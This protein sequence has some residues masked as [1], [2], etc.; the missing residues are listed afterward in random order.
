MIES[1]HPWAQ[2]LLVFGGVGGCVGILLGRCVGGSLSPRCLLLTLLLASLQFAV[3]D[4]LKRLIRTE[5]V[6][7]V[8]CADVLEII[9]PVTGSLCVPAVDCSEAIVLARGGKRGWF[10]ERGGDLIKVD[11][12]LKKDADG[13]YIY[14]KGPITSL[15]PDLA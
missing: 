5:I 4:D 1:H 10:L 9:S 8:N 12:V 14:L 2:S 6:S 7:E 15:A 3:W 13:L 11:S